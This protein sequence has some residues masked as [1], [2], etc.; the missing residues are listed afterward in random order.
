[1]SYP[2][3][4]KGHPFR[5]VVSSGGAVTYGV[6]KMLA[7]IISPLV[8]HSPHQ[9]RNAQ[10]F[11]DQFKTISPEKREC[12]TSYDVKALF[13]SVQV[14]PTIFLIKHKLQQDTQLHH[15]TSMTIHYH[16]AG[17][18]PKNTYFLF[19]VKYYEQ[20]HSTNMVHL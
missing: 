1:M 9:I 15:R 6:A 4:T 12:N 20:V 3:F 18:L 5:P 8:G 11:V 17:V 19:Q 13:T 16:T 7:N 10:N 2:K 14:D